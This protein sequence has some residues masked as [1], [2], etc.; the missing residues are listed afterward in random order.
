MTNLERV[1]AIKSQSK[2]VLQNKVNPTGYIYQGPTNLNIKT[3]KY[4]FKDRQEN[5]FFKRIFNFNNNA[6]PHSSKIPSTGSLCQALFLPR[7][8]ER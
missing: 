1:K 8:T 7:I 6:S 2:Q 3:I 5:S 4:A